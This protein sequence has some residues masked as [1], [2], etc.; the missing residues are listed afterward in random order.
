MSIIFIYQKRVQE[1]YQRCMVESNGV[2]I[3]TKRAVIR[4]L[5]VGFKHIHT[6]TLIHSYTRNVVELFDINESLH[7]FL[8][9]SKK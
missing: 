6:L 4:Y 3:T 2:Y 5:H 9:G 1:G 7:F 8:V